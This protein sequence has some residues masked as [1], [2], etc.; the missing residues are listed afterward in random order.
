MTLSYLGTFGLQG[1]SLD[2]R[3]GKGRGVCGENGCIVHWI[4]SWRLV[5]R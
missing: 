1:V 2:V 5:L 4:S 3:M